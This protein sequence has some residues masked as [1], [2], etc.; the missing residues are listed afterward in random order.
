MR[1]YCTGN[2]YE[3]LQRNNQSFSKGRFPLQPYRS[4]TY[5]ISLFCDPSGKTN[6]MDTIE[7]ATFRYDTVEVENG[8][9]TRC[10]LRATREPKRCPSTIIPSFLLDFLSK[11]W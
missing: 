4:E 11:Y 8:L 1:S 3:R 6:D 7:Y 9:K 2:K 10:V 5:R